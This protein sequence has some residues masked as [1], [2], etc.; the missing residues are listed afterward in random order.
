MQRD[1]RIGNLQFVPIR[2]LFAREDRDFTVWLSENIEVLDAQLGLSLVVV[3]REVRVGN[4]FADLLCQD[5]SGNRV[6]IENQLERS[7]HDHFGKLMTYMGNLGANTG[8]WITPEPR[9]EHITA[10]EQINAD[11]GAMALYLVAIKGVK[12]DNISRVA[13]L[14]SVV[15]RPSSNIVQTNFESIENETT[16]PDELM[17][18]N[19]IAAPVV[20]PSGFRDMSPVWVIHPKRDKETYN[21]FLNERVIGLGF[22]HLGDLRKLE[23]NFEAFKAAWTKG[24]LS[25]IL[26][27]NPRSVSQLSSMV[28]R[29]IH[30]VSVGD[31]IVYAPTW[32]E[33][34][35]YVGRVTG[36]Y[37]FDGKQR[38]GYY[39]LRP[40]EWIADF[41]RDDFSPEA[42]RGISVNLALFQVQNEIFLHELDEKL[43]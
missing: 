11:N 34:S 7:D 6:V 42:L 1:D 36:N 25:K 29:F 31:F 8:V 18:E 10:V 39:D 32:Y 40:V 16:Q 23:P 27:E 14:F 15:V 33:R 4:F 20:Q 26:R 12:I 30:Q 17:L 24:F 5:S 2:E 28:Y 43:S 38:Q 3:K 35:I 13:P 37:H 21:L 9:T 22:S 19:E 41:R